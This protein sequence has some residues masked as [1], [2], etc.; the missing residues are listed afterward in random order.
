[1]EQLG[2]HELFSVRFLGLNV[3]PITSYVLT[4]KAIANQF[5]PLYN[6]V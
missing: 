4:N 5:L 3:K 2:P 1:M 6:K